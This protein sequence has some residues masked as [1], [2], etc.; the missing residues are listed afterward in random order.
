MANREDDGD[1]P[2]DS[3]RMM[4]KKLI[5]GGIDDVEEWLCDMSNA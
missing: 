1:I 3:I 5:D 2:S 4:L